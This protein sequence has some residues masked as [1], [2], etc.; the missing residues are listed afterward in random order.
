MIVMKSRDI[1]LVPIPDDKGVH[2]KTAGAKGEKYVYK[3]VKYFRNSEGQPRNKARSI[4]KLSSEPGMMIPNNNYFEIY[5][6]AA[7]MPDVAVWD[8]GYTWL[9]QKVCADIGL[10]GILHAIFG[11]RSA[12]MI[13]MA[14]FI[15]R[16]GNVMDHL[17]EWQERNYFPNIDHP[18]TSPEASRFF[19]GITP[20]ERI[21]FFRLWVKHHYGGKSVCYDVT[22]ISS[23]ASNLPE[24]ERGYNRDHEDLAQF[25][26]GMFCDEDTRMPL[27]YDR[28]NGSLT[29]RSNLSCALTNAKDVGIEHVHMFMDGGFWSEECIQSLARECD[30]F[31]LGMPAYLTDAEQAIEQCRNQIERYANELPDCH[32]Y[33]MEIPTTLYGVVGKI[34]VYYDPW[35]HVNLCSELSESIARMEAQ[36]KK[37]R[38]Y[39]KS[40]LKYFSRYFNITKHAADS[41]FDYEADTEKIESL[42]KNKGFFLLFTNDIEASASSLLYYYRAKDADE[43]LFAQIKVDMDGRRIRT[44]NER[45]TDGKTFVTFL[46]CVIRS[47]MLKQLHQYLQDNSTSMNKVYNQLSNIIMIESNGEQHFTKALTKKQREILQQFNAYTAIMTSLE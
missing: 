11:S 12:S 40:K 37:C 47:Y 21:A 17:A 43:K 10:T 18:I 25:N 28:Y 31:T 29:D 32:I 30:A 8:Y 16:E 34:L 33:C 36:L 1:Q 13:A 4:G 15:I 45:T 6:V 24:V 26:L 3:Y 22:S 23:Y 35:N 42:R 20:E 41:G 14:A 44:H 7:S 19:A 2:I 38:R 5:K 27:Y 9:A 39:P 46:A